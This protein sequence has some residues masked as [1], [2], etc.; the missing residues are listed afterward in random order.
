MDAETGS[1]AGQARTGAPLK[2]GR[3][4][5]VVVALLFA[6]TAINYVD[7]QMIGVLKPTLSAEF[8]WTESDF[9]GIVFWFQ[10]AYAIGYLSF[11][12]IV[13]TLG[14]RLG[15][16]LAIVIWTVSHM[17]HGFATGITSFAMARFG[18]GLGESGNFPAGI[19]AVT[20]WFPQKERALAIGIFNAG[21]N[22]GA[23]VT[24]LLVPLLVL[25][26]DWRMA[27][28]VTGLF[29]ILWLGAWWAFYRHP[30]S[31]P[32]VTP[33][34]LA[35]IRQDPADPV[36]KIGWGRLLIVRETWAYALG[37]FLI[38]PIWWFF[39]FWLPGYLFDRYDLDLKT[40]GLPLAAIYLISDVGSIAGGWMSSK[41]IATGRSPN[42]ARKATMLLCAVCVLP[43]WFVQGV[44]N[45]WTAVLIIGL[46]TAAHQAFSANLYTLPSDVFPRGAV[47]SVVGIGG[48]AGAVGGMG[49]ALF[50]GYIL[51][52]THSY[53][54]LFA[55]CASA[56][57]LALLAVHVLSPR[58]RPVSIEAK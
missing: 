12:K 14:A 25:W 33:Q 27:F 35:Y 45:V 48:T 28:F 6:A 57:L 19:R 17:A 38:D 8:N 1:T 40:F 52:A 23:I 30:S 13:D 24:P 34:E 22:V 54:V 3:Y 26:F 7:R 20:D 11:G 39:L 43:I 31:H 32:H 2:V 55:I 21:A 46:A 9:A 56:Y 4:R 16:V 50:A 36:E 18:L 5:W 29:G 42:F 49:M 37:K 15:Y 10:L 53:E 41:L 47:G 58:L 51:D 44:D